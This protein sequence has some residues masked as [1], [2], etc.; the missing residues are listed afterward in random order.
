MKIAKN[1]VLYMRAKDIGPA[2][3]AACS[4]CMMFI[5]DGRCT[6]VAGEIDGEKGVC[7]LYVQGES[8]RDGK[9]GVLPQAIASYA[10]VAPTHCGNCKFYGGG[11]S[12]EGQCKIVE[13]MVEFHGCCN[14]WENDN[15]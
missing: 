6:S 7:G 2:K 3:G 10:L 9:S 5:K 12:K 11:Q 4:G 1:V 15:G 13:G 14:A 8:Q